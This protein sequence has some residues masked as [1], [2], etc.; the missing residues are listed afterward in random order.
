M[1]HRSLKFWLIGM[2]ISAVVA[3]SMLLP[4]YPHFFA[5]VFGVTDAN[6]IGLYL[7]ACCFAVILALPLWARLVQHTGVLRLLVCTQV[8]AGLLSILCY[9]TDT[10]AVFWLVSLGMLVFKASYLLIYPMIM[11]EE[12]QDRH[13]GTIGLLSV[14]VHLGGIVGAV[15]GGAVLQWFEPRQVFLVMSVSDFLQT[16]TCLYLLRRPVN[17]DAG[18]EVAETPSAATPG[19]GGTVRFLLPL[20]VVMFGFYFSA[21]L[22]RP[23]FVRHWESASALTNEVVSGLV[24]AIPAAIAIAALWLNLRR[25]AT[26]TA[27]AGITSAL[28]L[29]A[30]G[31]LIQA[32]DQPLHVLLGRCLFGWGLFQTT[33]R[34]DQ[35][36][37]ALSTPIRYAADFS[38]INFCQ[39]FGVLVASLVAG[40]LVARFELTTPFVAGAAGL[41]LTAIAFLVLVRPLLR[42]HAQSPEPVRSHS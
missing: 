10:L 31:L 42:S 4:F 15:L 26:A 38:K 14:V 22:I 5:T 1:T 2:T 17:G 39:Q 32:S 12:R 7:S 25:N 23:F 16:A 40:S 37:F 41:L 24:F 27:G 28:L 30:A 21:Y 34:L 6:H 18:R 3:D 20:G 9:W 8:V 29:A 33:V 13:G 19:A 35:L 11:A 36:L